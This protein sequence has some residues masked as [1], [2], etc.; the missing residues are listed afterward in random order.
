MGGYVEESCFKKHRHFRGISYHKMGFQ[1]GNS[2]RSIT[3]NWFPWYLTLHLFTSWVAFQEPSGDVWSTIVSSQALLFLL[4]WKIFK[5]EIGASLWDNF[6][7]LDARTFIY[8]GQNL[9]FF[10]Q[11]TL[12]QCL[13][14]KISLWQPKAVK[15]L[16]LC[17]ATSCRAHPATSRSF[18]AACSGP[19]NCTRGTYKSLL[20]VVHLKAPGVNTPV[21]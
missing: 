11:I 3:I 15:L 19:S 1:L 17:W 21:S 18:S 9:S 6:S 4:L 20:A 14:L 12:Q 8:W 13:K 10:C 7:A 16:N 2:G 5:F